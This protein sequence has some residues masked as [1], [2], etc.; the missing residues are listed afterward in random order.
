MKLRIALAEDEPIVLEDLRATVTELGHEVIATVANGR[1][2]VERCQELKPDLVITDINMPDLDGLEAAKL[3]RNGVP[4]PIIV[5]SAFHD[6]EIVQRA[7]EEHVLAYLVKPL[8]KGSLA[9]AIGIVMRRFRE[10]Q[11]VSEHAENLQQ[12]L[13][14]RKLIE[15]AK[16][17][18]MK[19]AELTEEDAFLRLQKLSRTKNKKM[20]EIA[21]SLIDAEEAFDG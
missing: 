3:L 18:L 20:I 4:I 15:R 10:F 8:H 5:V 12:A 13:D 16:G 7:E 11:A 2:L 1:E 14:E 19:R 17:I 9:T 21:R 6:P